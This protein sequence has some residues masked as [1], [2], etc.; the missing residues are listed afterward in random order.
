MNATWNRQVGG[1]VP[2]SPESVV[3]LR[4]RYRQA[5]DPIID[6]ESV[7]LGNDVRPDQL[8]RCVFDYFDGM[9]LV[10]SVEVMAGRGEYLHLAAW[11]HD[12]SELHAADASGDFTASLFALTVLERF[13]AISGDRG[14]MAH[15]PT[16]TP[17]VIH[18][19]RPLSPSV[20]GLRTKD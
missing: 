10:I 5:L 6:V 17:G 14:L 18:F 8:R 16:S 4:D 19:A 3:V 9:R 7:L 20:E 11:L 15:W 12:P 2:Y 1:S 13:A